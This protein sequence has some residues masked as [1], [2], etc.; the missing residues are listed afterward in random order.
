M[1]EQRPSSASSG[2]CPECFAV[3]RRAFLGGSLAVIGGAI[4][5]TSITTR[6]AM[7]ASGYAGDTLVVVSL[8][9]GFDGLSAIVP[10]GE[11]DYLTK[12]P[13]IAVPKNSLLAADSLFGLHPAMAAL[14]PY[15]NAGTFGAVHAVGQ[16]AA[17]RS[18][19]NA[20]DEMERAAPN[21]SIRTG[22]IDRALGQREMTDVFSA[23]QVGGGLPT[24]AFAGP[25]AELTMSALADFSIVGTAEDE[26]PAWGRAERNRWV[27]ALTDLAADSPAA[28]RTPT[29]IALDAVGR[30]AA[31]AGA[32]YTPAATYPDTEFGRALLDVARLIKSDLAIQVACV[33]VG[34][35]DMHEGLG[36]AGDADAWMTR[37]LRELSDCLAAFATDLGNKFASTTIVTM[38]EFGRRVQENASGGV[39]H[40]LGNAM[41]L[42]G[43]NVVGGRVHGTWP[44]LED[45]HLDD[46]D[47]AGANDFRVVL[48]EIL[49]KR[50]QQAG[51]GTV[52]PGA[53]LNAQLGVVRA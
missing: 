20:M 48:A 24:K 29:S 5:S 42:L 30:A 44:G 22:W 27:S 38:S 3:S 21:S 8:R 2:Q 16:P 28:I 46:G 47:L 6:V 49:S 37:K 15:W 35:W 40:G 14:V 31:L 26:D 52:F 12:R 41:L 33:D 10:H 4:A 50:C 19:F 9:G 25:Q 11:P 39:D 7:A 13:T 23:V 36:Q 51:L 32:A 34:D 1:T 17:S 45:R 18:H 53:D 43:G